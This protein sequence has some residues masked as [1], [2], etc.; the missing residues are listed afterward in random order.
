MDTSILGSTPEEVILMAGPS[1]HSPESRVQAV[2]L[3][4]VSDKTVAKVARDLGIN[5]TLWAAG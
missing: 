4:E 3:I 2:D 5:D 1:K